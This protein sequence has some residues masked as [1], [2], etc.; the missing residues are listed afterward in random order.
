MCTRSGSRRRPLE[1]ADGSGE[2]FLEVATQDGVRGNVVVYALVDLECR[3]TNRLVGVE[4]L[5][6]Q[7]L[8]LHIDQLE[9]RLSATSTLVAATAATG[10]ADEAHAK[11]AE[12]K[13]SGTT[14]R[15]PSRYQVTVAAFV[16]VSFGSSTALMPGPFSARVAS[17]PND[18]RVRMETA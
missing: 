10:S 3:I 12:E 15:G 9:R 16:A 7:L 6:G 8:V 14:S 2:V 4:G 1:D 17:R 13:T 18:A 11:I 5:L